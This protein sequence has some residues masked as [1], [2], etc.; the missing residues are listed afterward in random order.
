[1]SKLNLEANSFAFKTACPPK[2]NGLCASTPIITFAFVWLTNDQNSVLGY[3]YSN[4][5]FASFAPFF[6]PPAFISK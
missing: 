3:K 4:L 2:S 6:M 1:M 5:P